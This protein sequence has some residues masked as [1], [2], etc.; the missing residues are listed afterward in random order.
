MPVNDGA[1]PAI[2]GGRD[3]RSH[4][5]RAHLFGTDL[6]AL[7]VF[8]LIGVTQYSVVFNTRDSDWDSYADARQ[9]VLD[10][11]TLLPGVRVTPQVVPSATAVAVPSQ[12]TNPRGRYGFTVPVGYRQAGATETIPG[13]VVRLGIVTDTFVSTLQDE[14]NFIVGANALDPATQQLS[15]D[16]LTARVRDGLLQQS[17]H[18]EPGDT[19]IQPLTL[20]GQEARSF[21][22]HLTRDNLPRIHATVVVCV[23]GDVAYTL[24]FTSRD[25]NDATLQQ[26]M[27][28]VVASF[29]ILPRSGGTATPTP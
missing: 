12:F 14:T 4:E 29:V 13:F 26:D 23:V 20:A 5:F 17:S 16:D 25:E 15:L 11:F 8:T 28:Q 27:Q 22:L 1:Q 10:S 9:Q 19:D 24:S 21:D 7:V 3:A 6:R 2:L 18:L